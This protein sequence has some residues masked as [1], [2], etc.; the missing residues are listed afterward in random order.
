MLQ[1]LPEMDCDKEE[2][3]AWDS[4]CE[5]ERRGCV[6]SIAS[7]PGQA[8]QASHLPLSPKSKSPGGQLSDHHFLFLGHHAAFNLHS[9]AAAALAVFLQPSNTSDKIFTSA[10]IYTS[11]TSSSVIH[12]RFAEARSKARNRPS[13][14]DSY[15]P[16]RVFRP[17]L[18]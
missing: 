15:L 6:V 5:G 10:L 3:M 16:S 4:A 8:S 7:S 18:Y 11:I 14:D 17:G 2:S 13:K 1:H 12:G 9:C